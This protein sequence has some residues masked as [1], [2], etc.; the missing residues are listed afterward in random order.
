MLK[1]LLIALVVV[2]GPLA[3]HAGLP[4]EVSEEFSQRLIARGALERRVNGQDFL[5]SIDL[6]SHDVQSEAVNITV[7]VRVQDKEG[8]LVSDETLKMSHRLPATHHLIDYTQV[9]W[10]S[11]EYTHTPLCVA[12]ARLARD[13]DNHIVETLSV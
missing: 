8:N 13:L 6:L 12:H 11:T 3:V 5:V 7:C 10:G 9:G 1:K 4:W 2:G